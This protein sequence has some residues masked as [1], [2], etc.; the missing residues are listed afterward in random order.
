VRSLN[1]RWNLNDFH[2]HVASLASISTGSSVLDLGCGRRN[3]LPHLLDRI[4]ASGGLVAADRDRPSLDAIKSAY[5]RQ[6]AER[7]LTVVG[8]DIARE[9]PFASASFNSVVCQ[10]VIECLADR[11]SL[12]KEV[13]RI[14]RPG[15]TALI[16]HHDFDG[17][18]IASADRHLTRRLVHGYADFTQPWQDASE[19]Q[20][21][22]LLPGLFA[23]GPFNEVETETTLFVDLALAQDSYA[24]CHLDDIVALCKR[25]DVDD[26]QAKKW[27]LDLEARSRAGTFYYALPWTNVIAKRI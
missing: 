10:N 5:A 25:F 1:P 9:L 13:H 27:L 17:V 2:A 19:G 3:G 23:R 14:L 18:L 20:M 21:G 15:G 8:L 16:G 6:I 11:D 4:G 24:R 26:E 12:I 7:S 22:R